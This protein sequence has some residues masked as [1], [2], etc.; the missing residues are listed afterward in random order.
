MR[1]VIIGLTVMVVAGCAHA[2]G[3]APG[4]NGM[5]VY[6]IRSGSATML[7]EKAHEMCPQGYTQMSEPK[8]DA[9]GQ[10]HMAVECR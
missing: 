9:G 2:D 6:M 1:F 3:G 4:P 7:F 8:A 10:Y 5:P